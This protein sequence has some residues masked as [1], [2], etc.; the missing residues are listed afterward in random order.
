MISR[1]CGEIFV[2]R[3][4]RPR[5][6]A[7][8]TCFNSCHNKAT[9]APDPGLNSSQSRH[10][11]RLRRIKQDQPGIKPNGVSHHQDSEYSRFSY[12]DDLFEIKWIGFTIRVEYCNF[13]NL[14][15]RYILQY[16]QFLTILSLQ[17]QQIELRLVVFKSDFIF[18]GSLNQGHFLSMHDRGRVDSPKISIF[19]HFF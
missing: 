13:L 4:C 8:D 16:K 6:H 7:L 9:I 17:T 12:L 19:L 14:Y 18:A 1:Q 5:K 11:P 2:I 3:K 15:G 10:E